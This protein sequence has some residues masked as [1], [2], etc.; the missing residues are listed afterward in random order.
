MSNN[1]INNIIRNVER[2][3]SEVFLEIEKLLKNFLSRPDDIVILEHLKKQVQEV[4]YISE[5]MGFEKSN[6]LA[7]SLAGFFDEITSGGKNADNEVLNLIL[8]S[9]DF[10]GQSIRMEMEGM[11]PGPRYD[12]ILGQLSPGSS[13]KNTGKE[14]TQN[15]QGGSF[16]Q[17]TN[18]EEAPSKSKFIREPSELTRMKDSPELDIDGIDMDSLIN[19]SDE[20]YICQTVF[21]RAVN[22]LARKNPNNPNMTSLLNMASELNRIFPAIQ[23]KILKVQRIWARNQSESLRDLAS[24]PHYERLPGSSYLNHSLEDEILSRLWGQLSTPAP[25]VPE[26]NPDETDIHGIPSFSSPYL[27]DEVLPDEYE[28]GEEFWGFDSTGGEEDIYLP[29]EDPEFSL[30]I[31]T[32]APGQNPGDTIANRLIGPVENKDKILS[33]L[34]EI[35]FSSPLVEGVKIFESGK[36]Y[37]ILDHKNIV[38]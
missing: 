34:E 1:F 11:S 32:P 13:G 3:V 21:V 22:E 29:G 37:L 6:K 18:I 16:P 26:I 19:A 9:I 30:N 38:E 27:D 36:A 8:I 5:L 24:E 25:F 14:T 12:F 17:E 28:P 33:A 23:D 10:L 20:L 15:L 2:K 35:D 7:H 31:S 4:Q